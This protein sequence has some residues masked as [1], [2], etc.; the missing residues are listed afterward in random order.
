MPLDIIAAPDPYLKTVSDPVGVVDDDLRKLMDEM[1]ETMYGA[2]GIGL[3]GIQ[4]GVPKRLLVMDVA[5]DDEPARPRFII[6]PEII[7]Q[8]EEM[9]LY[10]EGCL[11]VPEHY[12]EVERPSEVRIKYL[13]YDG[14]AVEETLDGLEATCVQ[15]E[16]DHLNGV[17][18]IDHLSKLRR[19]MI[20]KRLRKAQRDSVIL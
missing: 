2:P 14:Q 17:L 12:A 10:N 19:D 8:S 4:V 18:F 20:V 7:W 1:L 3:A 5:G 13:G 16:I 9:G 11:S 15:H 6:N